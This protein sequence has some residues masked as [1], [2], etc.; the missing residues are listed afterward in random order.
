MP[1]A[2]LR[3]IH[4]SPKKLR[5]VADAIRGKKVDEALAM[6]QFMEKGGA[7]TILKLLKS[8]IANAGANHELRADDLYVAKITIDGAA[9]MKR[10]MARARGRAARIRCR[11]SHAKI[12]L[13]ETNEAIY[14]ELKKETAATAAKKSV[15]KVAKKATTKKAATKAQGG[16]E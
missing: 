5:L 4:T 2:I 15:K 8:A 3:N 1:R 7:P 9:T 14:R 11:T 16:K 13:R 10:F 12:V 6:L